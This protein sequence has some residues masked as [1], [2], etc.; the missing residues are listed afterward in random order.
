[1]LLQAL[2]A[3]W[4]RMVVLPSEV[5][6]VENLLT[7]ALEQTL[8]ML[9]ILQPDLTTGLALTPMATLTPHRVIG[10]LLLHTLPGVLLPLSVTRLQVTRTGV[11]EA[12]L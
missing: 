2:T 6:M 8:V 4:T 1:M 3:I 7:V 5:L 11:V 9:Q 12:L 10:L